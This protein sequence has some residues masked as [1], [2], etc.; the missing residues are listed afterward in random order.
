MK[1]FLG[2]KKQNQLSLMKINLYI[3]GLSTNL[4]LDPNLK[5][6]IINIKKEIFLDCLLHF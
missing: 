5:P 3:C 6:F 1:N 4:D 2:K